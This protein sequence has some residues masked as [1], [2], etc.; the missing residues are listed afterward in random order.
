MNAQANWSRP[1]QLCTQFVLAVLTRVRSTSMRSTRIL[2]P[3]TPPTLIALP[4]NHV[5]TSF[6]PVGSEADLCVDD[7]TP[8]HTQ[9]E[10]TAMR[11]A[12]KRLSLLAVIAVALLTCA[13]WGIGEA[14]HSA[15]ENPPQDF[16]TGTAW[17]V[18][19]GNAE[20]EVH[21]SA[22]SGPLG[23]NPD[24][25]VVVFYHEGNEY[26]RDR[27]TCLNVTGNLAVIGVEVVETTGATFASPA[28]GVGQYIVVRDNG[29]PG[30]GVDE[31]TGHPFFFPPPTVW[32][33][34]LPIV[35][36]VFQGN[37]VVHDGAP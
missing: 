16:V 36:Q 13:F 8:V 19:G 30:A 33:P 18:G 1:K 7:H 14:T 6:T 35:Q 21:I 2:L 37:Y 20:F 34:V 31:I 10:E 26:H 32:P 27:V 17:H 22:H 29:E 28:A 4:T 11:L 23:E 24:G 12:V 5:N 25:I 3:L 9:E 15:G